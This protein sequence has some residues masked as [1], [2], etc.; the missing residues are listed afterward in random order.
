M[1]DVVRSLCNLLAV[2][3]INCVSWAPPRS[4]RDIWKEGG[5]LSSGLGLIGVDWETTSLP[6]VGGVCAPHS[7]ISS[8]MGVSGRMGTESDRSVSPYHGHTQLMCCGH[9]F[10]SRRESEKCFGLQNLE[11][12]IWVCLA[13]TYA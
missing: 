12:T 1:G 2:S 7:C 8:K 10:G 5:G 11:H 13:Q 4:L 9:H 6:G 3:F